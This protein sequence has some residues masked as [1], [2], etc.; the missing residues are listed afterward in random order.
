MKWLVLLLL[1]T[2]NVLAENDTATS[3][4]IL[5]NAGTESSSMDNFNLDG[6][7]SGTTGNLTNNSTHN[8]FTITC[9]VEVN[10][11]C[12]RAFNG[13]LEASYQMK[14][15][16]DGTLI[17]IDG[18]ESNTTYTTT[19]KKLDGGIHLN[20]L[21]SMQNCEWGGSATPCGRSNGAQDTYKLH[22]KIK[23]A[24]GNT[25][26]NM[27]TIRMDDSGYYSNSVQNLDN[28]VYNGTGAASYEW[29]WE[30]FDGS[31]S[32]T[33]STLGPNL[34]G[35]ELRLDFPIE[36]HEALSEQE[37]EDINDALDTVDLTENEIYDIIS[38]LESKIEEEFRL[39]GKLEEG[40]RLEVSLEENGLTFE[41]A[42][43]ETGAIVMESP[44]VQQTFGS[45]METKSIETLKEEIVA[46]AQE[47]MP[48]MEM[49]E[50]L[51]PP[52]AMEE[53][54]QEEEPK[55]MSAGPMVEEEPSEEKPNEMQAGPIIETESPQEE[56]EETT[57]EE[58]IEMAEK[59][60]EEPEEKESASNNTTASVVSSKK[61]IKQKKVQSKKNINEK[62]EK[63]MT[64][65][66]K[67]IK[68]SAKNLQLKS[69]IK[70]DVMIGEQLSLATYEN[71]E[72][73]KPKSIYLDQL[74]IQ[75]TRKI[76]ADITLAKYTDKDII[77]IKQKQLQLLDD[78][79]Q[80]LLIEL[81]VLK[82]G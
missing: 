49:M 26:A 17:G 63:V 28:L 42:S 14:V 18:I 55:P 44:M 37:I 74:N 72:F 64:K 4:N 79:K 33:T 20:S 75:D 73:Y 29:Y 51:S 19:Q 38:G 81:E 22:I 54:P 45:A 65:I 8:G 10:N 50:E 25:L 67:E 30:G 69:L 59:E 47:E 61:N 41:I 80:Q 2:S 43:Q 78:K 46:M 76:Y 82:N 13:E 36:D 62:L 56:P 52:P 34:L 77:G 35:A 27:T 15:A 70:M 32:T 23:D 48:F 16:A 60:N 21:I 40:T 71:V 11:A 53:P 3:T 57:T 68:N 9:P 5:P 58:P 24:A 12:G 6:V 31:L 1:L 7:Q 39:T 66:D